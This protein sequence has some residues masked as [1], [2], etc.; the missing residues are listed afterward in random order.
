MA[1]ERYAF[2]DTTRD[3]RLRNGHD[4][5]LD[6]ILVRVLLVCISF[7]SR[8]Y[9]CQCIVTNLFVDSI[10]LRIFFIMNISIIEKQQNL[11][12]TCLVV[13]RL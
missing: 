11:E 13:G 1:K 5:G 4:I 8:H 3:S 7:G 12:E 2:R 6:K 9:S 10:L